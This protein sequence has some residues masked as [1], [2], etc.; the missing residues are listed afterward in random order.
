MTATTN[1]KPAPSIEHP[2]PS[3]CVR[4]EGTEDMGVPILHVGDESA[5]EDAE[6]TGFAG[7]CVALEGCPGSETE[8][9]YQR[10]NVY[11]ANHSHLTADQAE[12]L[13]GKLV[14]L[15]RQVRETSPVVTA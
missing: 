3:W 13:A 5:F 10:V 4:H 11:H 8:A 1:D 2:C 15:A 14:E 7:V 12:A 9:A 6:D